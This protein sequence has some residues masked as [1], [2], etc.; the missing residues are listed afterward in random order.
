MSIPPPG[1]P[2]V[3]LYEFRARGVIGLG[4]VKQRR[5]QVDSTVQVS[6]DTIVQ[7]L[8]KKSPGA[9]VALR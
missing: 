1:T 5:Q 2:D 3:E 9:I 4:N 7:V 8:L 6:M